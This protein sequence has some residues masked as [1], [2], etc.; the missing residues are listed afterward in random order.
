MYGDILEELRDGLKVTAE[1]D[2]RLLKA[3]KRNARGL[4]RAYNF[5][6][7]VR[8][9]VVP[10][11]AGAS[12][13]ALPADAGKVKVVML[14]T[15]DG[16]TTLYK[17]LRRRTEELIPVYA[18]PSFYR[19][20]AS[21]FFLDQPMPVDAVGYSVLIWYQS[22]DPDINEAWLSDTYGDALEHRTGREMGL[23]LN[24]AEIAQ[25]Y[26]GLWEE[27]IAILGRYIPELE[28][29]DLDLGLGDQ[30][31]VALERYPAS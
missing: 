31:T 3:V 28:F 24:K 17:V 27:D 30:R 12:S 2:G 7:A 16:G 25:V 21:T 8:K 1:Y 20:E 10:I 22:V 29:N 4:L 19:I 23:K 18:G 9:A 5:R 15:V 11:A 13:F 26:A 14:T 6:E